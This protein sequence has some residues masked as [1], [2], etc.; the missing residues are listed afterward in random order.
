MAEENVFEHFSKMDVSDH[1]EKKMGLSYLSWA[2]AWTIIK[3][4]DYDAKRE[5]TK[6]DELM[7]GQNTGRKVDYMKTDTGTYVECTLTIKGHSETET[8]FVMDYKNKAVINPDQAQINKA[9]QRC[10]VK[11]AALFGLGL[12]LYAG[13]DLP[14]ASEDKPQ[15][16]AKAK[17]TTR[18]P[19]QQKAPAKKPD[20]L[21][22]KRD[23]IKR[24]Y[25]GAVEQLGKENADVAFKKAQ[26][27][28]QADD[29]YMLNIDG[30]NNFINLFVQDIKEMKNMIGAK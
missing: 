2:W 6:F 21:E 11:A 29:V 16:P 1:V 3:S 12:N 28:L 22:A 15:Q 14:V 13:E 9:K 8:L 30:M 26:D 24:Y 17:T 25:A 4:Y 19:A 20:E 7:N 18:K 10:F 5:Y 23:L 27:T